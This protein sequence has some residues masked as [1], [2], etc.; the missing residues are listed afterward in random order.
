MTRSP[1]WP[2]V[3]LASVA[4]P[5][6][7][8]QADEPSV[9][10]VLADGQVVL[11]GATSQDK[12]ATTPEDTK[13]DASSGGT[14]LEDVCVDTYTLYLAASGSCKE[15]QV[16]W[17][18]DHGYSRV[19]ESPVFR[20]FS[21]LDLSLQGETGLVVYVRV[22]TILVDFLSHKDG[23]WGIT[24]SVE[25]A[26]ESDAL[27]KVAVSARIVTLRRDTFLMIEYAVEDIEL[28][29]LTQNAPLSV[30]KGRTE[31]LSVSPPAES[32]EK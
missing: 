30:W 11:L 16:L 2:L 24:K 31:D 10:R 26:H 21:I 22:A 7:V 6:A 5:V 32:S 14:T 19:S 28:W 29:H 23:K 12:H 3:M 18:C 9:W 13:R 15:S 8:L 17:T 1:F 27:G 20:R 25:L 4:M